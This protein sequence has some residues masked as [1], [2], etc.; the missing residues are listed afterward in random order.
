LFVGDGTMSA[1][2]TRA[3]MA[4]YQHVD[5]SPWPLTGATAAAMEAW[6]T[7][8]GAQ[9]EAGA[10]ERVCRTNDR[11]HEGLA[12]EGEECERACCAQGGKAAWTERVVVMR[13]PMHA[14]PQAAG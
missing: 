11:G 5:L 1:W 10:L 4:R 13:S 14:K 6:S 7:A 12:A 2:D 3:P 8:G 9:G